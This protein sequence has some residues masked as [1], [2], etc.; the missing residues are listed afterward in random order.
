MLSFILKISD[1]D[2]PWFIA[3]CVYNIDLF[4]LYT[5]ALSLRTPNISE[6]SYSIS[7]TNARSSLQEIPVH[8]PDILIWIQ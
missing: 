7:L 6:F 4:F 1:K 2:S 8:Q 3:C 5:F